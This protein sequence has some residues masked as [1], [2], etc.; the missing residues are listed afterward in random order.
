MITE[1]LIGLY[2]ETNFYPSCELYN[3][4]VIKD[5][6][7]TVPAGAGNFGLVWKGLLLGRIRVAMKASHPGIPA[8]VAMRVSSSP[9]PI[10]TDIS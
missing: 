1:Q 4:E 7:M 10:S 5:P 8:D 2:K 3:W 6:S 9:V